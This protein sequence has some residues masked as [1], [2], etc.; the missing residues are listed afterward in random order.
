LRDQLGLRGPAEVTVVQPADFWNLHNRAR[1]GKLDRPKVGG[2][3]VEREMSARL[4][5]IGNITS[6]DS[7]Q[8]SFA[9]DE[10]VVETL[11]P[12]GTDEAL[13]ERILPRAVCA[14]RTSLIC[15]LFTR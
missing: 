9:Q 12:D 7:T 14:V 6:Q 15:I 10:N 11:A 2:V 4:M 5:V 3:L 13:G 1:G 8:V